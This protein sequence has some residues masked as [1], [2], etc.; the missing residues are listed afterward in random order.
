MGLIESSLK[1]A[2]G[3]GRLLSVVF[4]LATL[5]FLVLLC[6]NI[7]VLVWGSLHSPD[8]LALAVGMIDAL[9]QNFSMICAFL[10]CSLVARDVSKGKTPFSDTQ[11]R[12]IRIAAWVMLGYTVFC[13]LWGPLAVTL[14][15]S[16]G[17]MAYGVVALQQPGDINLNFETLI[18]AGAF[19]LFAYILS[20]GKTLQDL[21]DEA[22]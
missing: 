1:K 10:V 4:M 9:V 20:Y 7:L 16:L 19:F 17:S 2:R 5:L 6:A 22:L 21:A 3:V 11:I 15:F 12:R 18:A 8:G 14:Q 13:L